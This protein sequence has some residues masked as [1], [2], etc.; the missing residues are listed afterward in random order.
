MR[1]KLWGLGK[2]SP[3]VLEMDA[4]RV[5]N[6]IQNPSPTFSP[7]ALLIVDCQELATNLEDMFSPLLKDLQI[8]LLLN[9]SGGLIVMSL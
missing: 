5:A 6:D 7:Y 9:Q 3:L 4:Q 1:L 8:S 2:L